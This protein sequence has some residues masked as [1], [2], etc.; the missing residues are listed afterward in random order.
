VSESPSLVPHTIVFAAVGDHIISEVPGNG[1]DVVQ[2]AP[3]QV[4]PHTTFG[5][6]GLPHVTLWQNRSEQLVPHVDQ[7]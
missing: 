5:D 6:P 3:P 1:L 4:D 7:L 2:F